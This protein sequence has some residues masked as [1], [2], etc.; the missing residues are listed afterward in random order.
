MIRKPFFLLIFGC[1]LI[2]VSIGFKTNSL[3]NALFLIGCS[4][5]IGAV[6]LKAEKLIERG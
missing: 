3:I 2:S 6:F 1:S 4:L 5:I